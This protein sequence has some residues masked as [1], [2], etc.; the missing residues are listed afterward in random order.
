M[1]ED[2]DD[3][4]KMMNLSDFDDEETSIM[5]ANNIEFKKTLGKLMGLS[6]KEA[7]SDSCFYCGK[8]VN[9]FCNSHSI[10]A[11]FLRNIAINGDLY[12]NNIMI[13]LPLI[14]DETGVNKT[15]T[16]HILCRECDSIIF[17]DYENPK[18]YNSTPTSKMLAQIAMKNFLRGISKRKLEIALYNNMASEL[19]LPKEFY[20][21]QQMVNELDLKENIEG[22]KRAKKINEKGWDN[23]YYLIYHKKLSYVVPLAF[24]SQLALQFDLEGNLIND[25]YYDSSKYKI[26]SM[27]L[28]VFPEENSSTI[29]MFIDS[30]DRRYRSFYKQFNKLSEDDKLSVINYMIF[31]LSEDVYLNKEINDII[32]ND[33]NLREVAGKTQHIFS[34]SPIKD[35]NAI[36]YDNLSFSQRH[37]IPNFLLEEYKVD[38]TS[39]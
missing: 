9:S 21:Q 14:D 25:I 1:F 27:H 33:N 39:E 31:S 16:F 11:M 28:C 30:K 19:G 8:K 2:F 3:I 24:Q 36:A 4:T 29:I 22:F 10:P 38:L 32:L 7:K 35:P 12:N 26:Q 37:R 20:E 6:R 34:I 18:N 17:R 13:K 23:E 5:E 15:G